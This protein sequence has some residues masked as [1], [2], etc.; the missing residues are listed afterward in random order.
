M[1]FSKSI[2]I[3]PFALCQST[4]DTTSTASYPMAD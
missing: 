1:V 3:S 2:V 4:S